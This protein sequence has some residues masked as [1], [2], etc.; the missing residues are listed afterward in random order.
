MT[1]FDHEWA[2]PTV[3]G[4][5]VARKPDV[6]LAYT[7]RTR[8]AMFTGPGGFTE[9]EMSLRDARAIADSIGVKLQVS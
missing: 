4:P 8:T 7:L 9:V 6:H 2:A 1:E 5:V 3:E